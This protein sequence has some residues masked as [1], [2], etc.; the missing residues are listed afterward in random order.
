MVLMLALGGY[1][2]VRDT[3]RQRGKWGINTKQVYCPNCDEPAPAVRI[4]K[5]WRQTLWGGCTCTNCGVEFDKWGEE[6]E[7]TRG[8]HDEDEIDDGPN[9]RR[10]RQLD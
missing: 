5:N 1:L 8:T 10:N 2:V 4:P 3:V 7:K 9:T 6:I